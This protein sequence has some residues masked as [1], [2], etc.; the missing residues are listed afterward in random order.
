LR[1]GQEQCVSVYMKAYS[2]HMCL[3]ASV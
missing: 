1:V 2:V 3:S